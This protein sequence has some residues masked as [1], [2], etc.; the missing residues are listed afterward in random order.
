MQCYQRSMDGVGLRVLS[1]LLACHIFGVIWIG[2]WIWTIFFVAGARCPHGHAKFTF[3]RFD[4]DL[5]LFPSTG[6][7]Y[8]FMFYTIDCY[9][10]TGICCSDTIHYALLF[11][12]RFPFPTRTKMIVGILGIGWIICNTTHKQ[13]KFRWNYLIRSM[14]H[15]TNDPVT[16]VMISLILYLMMTYYCS[17]YKSI[18]TNL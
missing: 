9:Q 6:F 10:I 13:T 12:Y 7:D 4:L 8:R 16:F 17:A 14:A 15:T 11:S 5:F 1:D 18:L 3:H 2:F